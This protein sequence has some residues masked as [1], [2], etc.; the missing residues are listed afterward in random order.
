MDTRLLLAGAVT[1]LFTGGVYTCVALG[2]SLLFGVLRF[3]N[4]AHGELV[5]G[6]AFLVYFLSSSGGAHPALALVA[7]LPL[8]FFL[9]YAI[10]RWLVNPLLGQGPEAPLL[11][12]F[13]LSIVVQNSLIQIWGGSSRSLH[14]GLET[15]GLRLLGTTV[16]SG[17]P[18]AFAV[19]MV[20]AVALHLVMIRTDIGRAIRA[21]ALD[22]GAARAMGVD[23]ERVYAL[24]AGLASLLAGIGGTLIGVAFSFTPAT[25]F[26]WLLKSFAVVVLGGMGQVLGTLLGALVLGLAEGIGGA[27]VGT[28]YRDMIG[29]LIFLGILAVRPRGLFGKVSAGE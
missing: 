6:A 19:A 24:S 14:T 18:L 7:V 26:S 11:T 29:F 27:L 25:G 1:G 4:V 9:G 22:P 28:G 13:G 23:V 10:Q 20:L 21:A 12:A 16:P 8:M 15:V 17:Y 2:L 3:I 5:I